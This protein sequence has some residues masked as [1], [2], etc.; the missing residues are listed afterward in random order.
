R[1]LC[2]GLDVDRDPAAV[3]THLDR[4]VVAQHDVDLRAVTDQCLVDRVVDNLPHAMHES[5]TVGRAD[6]HART[7]ANGLET[8]EYQEM[9]CRVVGALAA[10]EQ[11]A[12]LSVQSCG[13]I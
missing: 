9:P 12:C 10:G 8:L 11:R 7:L 2:L 6:V 13:A 3:V 5:A 4:A 1:Q